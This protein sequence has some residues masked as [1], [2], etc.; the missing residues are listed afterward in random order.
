MNDNFDIYAINDRVIVGLGQYQQVIGPLVNAT[1]S[2][3][4]LGQFIANITDSQGYEFNLSN[5]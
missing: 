5:I 3:N 2:T 4:Y 1:V